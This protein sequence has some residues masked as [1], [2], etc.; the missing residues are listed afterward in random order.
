[1]LI[2]EHDLIQKAKQGNM[3]AF[4]ELIYRYDKHVLAIAYNFRMNREDAKDIY[5]EVFMR[6][7]RS[8]K[9]FEEK[10]EFSTWLYRIVTN[11]CISFKRSQKKYEFVSINYNNDED[12]NCNSFENLIAD[13]IRTDNQLIDDEVTKIIWQAVESL[14]PQQ[15]LAFTY[16]YLHD[17]K[18]REI[19]VMMNCTESS[20]KKYL[21]IATRKIREKVKNL[22]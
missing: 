10:S 7:F 6:V 12:D 14:S 18:I 13:E 20:I 1:M 17:H 11:V 16:K 22:L 2:E 8:L 21:F 15:K 5:Q 9:N 3:E 4:E 19:A